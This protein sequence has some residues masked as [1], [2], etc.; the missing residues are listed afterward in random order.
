VNPH[1][2][3]GQRI[4]IGMLAVAGLVGGGALGLLF[5]IPATCA[6]G[7]PS[8][9]PHPPPPPPPEWLWWGWIGL[10]GAAAF[11]GAY[12]SI[13]LARR[14]GA[15]P[16]TVS[17]AFVAGAAVLAALAAGGAAVRWGS[18]ET[19]FA[20]LPAPFMAAVAAAF[21]GAA[22]VGTIP[23]RPVEP[24]DGMPSGRF[25]NVGCLVILCLWLLLILLIVQS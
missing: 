9:S 4:V 8:G 7:I 5:L 11:V 3:F 23:I 2:G 18:H 13:G 10:S 16:A 15:I 6:S 1:I 19:G 25:A 20:R 17:P 14:W 21:L 24:L 22:F 12:A